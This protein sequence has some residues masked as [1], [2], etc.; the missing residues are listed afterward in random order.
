MPEGHRA[1]GRVKAQCLRG[2]ARSTARKGL[3]MAAAKAGAIAIAAMS[4]EL[5]GETWACRGT[6]VDPIKAAPAPKE[7]APAASAAP[8]PSAKP[9]DVKVGATDGGA[10]D[11]G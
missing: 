2:C 6:A 7:P 9:A 4:C 11:A 10:P 1:L 8:A 3:K 5:S